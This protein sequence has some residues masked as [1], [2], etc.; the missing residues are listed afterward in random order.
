WREAEM[1]A[2]TPKSFSLLRVLVENAG[3]LVTKEE[4][5]EKVW[6]GT[7][8]TDAVLKVCVLEIRRALNENHKNPRFIQTLHR[9]GYRFIC[10]VDTAPVSNP[11]PPRTVAPPEISPPPV[12]I[13]REFETARF[14]EYLR[15]VQQG[16]RQIVFLSGE[17]GIGKTALVEHL[18]RMGAKEGIPLAIGQCLEHFGEREPYYPLLD[19]FQRAVRQWGDARILPVLRQH[20]PTWLAQMPGLLSPEE[21]D[22]LR[23]DVFGATRERMLREMSDA[24]DV[25]AAASPLVLVL[26]DLHWGDVSTLDWIR[27]VANRR[28]Q[29][30]LLVVATYRPVEVI[31]NNHPLKAL[32]QELV[33][34]KLASELPIDPL[35]PEAVQAYVDHRFQPNGFPVAFSEMLYR[36]SGGNS[37]FLV[38]I[39]NFCHEQG[40]IVNCGDGWCLRGDLQTLRHA[41][42]ET[43]AQVIEHQAEHLTAQERDLLETASVAGLEFALA[44][45]PRLRDDAAAEELCESLSKRKLF[46]RAADMAELPGGEISPRYAFIHAIYRQ[47]FYRGLSPARRI[48]LHQAAGTTIEESTHGDTIFAT[49]MAHHFQESHQWE[50]AIHYLCAAAQTAARRHAHHEASTLLHR[51]SK[52][53]ERLPESRRTQIDLDTREQIGLH[54]RLTGQL[55]RSILEFEQLAKIAARQDN[56]R[57]QL[58]A[59]LWLASVYSWNDRT[60]C[61]AASD[62]TVKLAES[63]TCADFR[64]NVRGQAA[65]WN[66]LF[67][68]WSHMDA[69]DSETALRAAVRTGDQALIALHASRHSYFQSLAGGYDAASDTAEIG[70]RA[71]F[72]AGNLADYAIGQYFQAWALLH[73]GRWGQME[74]LLDGATRLAQ[75]NRHEHWTILF[76]LMEAWLRIHAH[77]FEEARNLAEDCLTRARRVR[78]EFSQQMALVLLGQANTGLGD[79]DYASECFDELGE[80][81]SRQRILMDW[82]WQMPLQQGLAEL[83][84]A[85]GD[86]ERSQREA[87]RFLEVA[88]AAAEPTWRALSHLSLARAA[89]ILDQQSAF[90]NEVYTGL[91]AIERHDAPLAEWRLRALAAQLDPDGKH[92]DC[93]LAILDRLTAQPLSQDLTS[94]LLRSP[95]VRLLAGSSS[96]FAGV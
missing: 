5:L 52:A 83:H 2:L 62:E 9:R 73:A 59:K 92:R 89:L 95:E 80:W 71:A 15:R 33:A 67:R 20:A 40:I 57:A 17:P 94:S 3:R 55:E 14:E 1:I 32:K 64:A 47:F 38:N 61:L 22:R 63:E 75:R 68:G 34:R 29:S 28:E 8:V 25:L 18:L 16:S 56:P 26:E 10:P 65:Y 60:E 24:I 37:L 12:L 19:A 44:F 45:L 76:R 54:Y 86:P 77:S 69:R 87:A 7:F 91:A 39:S 85:S 21:S 46:L 43:L 4:L 66:L 48:K 72:D 58:K 36:L 6:P 49:E 41:V 11:A 53:V 31:L 88:E 90:E 50:K 79:F 78:H 70:L 13:G 93:A 96:E 74:Q 51:A 27:W 82:I 84:L 81:Q 23:A 35:S 30:R 42:P